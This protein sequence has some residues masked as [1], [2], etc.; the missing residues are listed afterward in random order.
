MGLRLTA[1]PL[2]TGVILLLLALPLAV[3]AQ[4][5]AKVPRI[6]VLLPGSPS[7]TVSPVPFVVEGLRALGYVEGRTIALAYRYAEGDLD[8]LSG[9]AAELTRLPVDVILADGVASALAAKQATTKIPIVFARATDPVGRGLVASLARPGGNITGVSFDGGPE[10]F[11]KRLE[12][13]KAAVPTVSR[14]AMLMGQVRTPTYEAVEKEC[15]R[16]ARGLG[17]TLRYFYVRRAEEFPERVFPA[18]TSD[19]RA[20]D[21]LHAGGPVAGQSR[22]QIADFALQHRLPT[23]GVNRNHAEAGSLLSYG[24]TGRE[25]QQRVAS[26]VDKILKGA[27]P[28][29][30][31]IEQPSSN[32][33]GNGRC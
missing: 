25:I 31:P 27:Q 9:L 8:R 28:A 3:D 30:L 15:E 23:M 1:T 4:P 10:I 21:A 24:P 6:G 2:A 20:I 11:G 14:V 29:D 7:T 19:A 18:I 26:L 33:A 22:R 16:A 5:P 13:L 32:C 12:L 17:L